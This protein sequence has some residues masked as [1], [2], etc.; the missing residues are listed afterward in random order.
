M[1]PTERALNGIPGPEVGME[2]KQESEKQLRKMENDSMI[3]INDH[4]K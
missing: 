3:M 2:E 4:N 1:N